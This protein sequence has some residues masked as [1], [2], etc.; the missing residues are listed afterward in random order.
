MRGLIAIGFFGLCALGSAAGAMPS[1]AESHR[2]MIAAC[3][4]VVDSQTALR[5]LP[6]PAL[7]KA[8]SCVMSELARQMNQDLPQQHDTITMDTV[9]P[10][11]ARLTY[12]YTFVEDAPVTTA[13]WLSTLN[14]NTETT[15]RRQACD[16]PF[17][18]LL[19]SLGASLAV[20]FRD[21]NGQILTHHVVTRC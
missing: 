18:R 4:A 8:L 13:G 14:S 15:L 7:R 2:Q 17:F 6:K 10:E 5:R 9:Q 3:G 21:R 19:I 16:P 20:T 1:D 11:G 12:R